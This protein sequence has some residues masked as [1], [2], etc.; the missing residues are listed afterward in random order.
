MEKQVRN[1][2]GSAAQ[3]VRR[4]LEQEYAEQ[5]DGIFD[6]KRSGSI[7]DQPGAHLSPAQR[8]TRS[9]IVA[10]IGYHEAAGLSQGEAVD[11]VHPRRRLHHPQPVRG[12]QDASKPAS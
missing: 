9:K 10:A 1:A 8:V 7:A 4:L 12:A 6:I 2:I 11:T 3:A 5:L